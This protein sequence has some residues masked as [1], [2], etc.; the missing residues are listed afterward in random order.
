MK[1]NALWFIA[2]VTALALAGCEITISDGSGD[3]KDNAIHL[4]EGSFKN[5]DLAKDSEQWFS[6]T[7]SSAGTYYIHV[8]FGTIEYLNVRVFTLGGSPIGGE[9]ALWE[10][11][12]NWS[13][14]REFPKSGTYHIRVR[15]YYPGD[16]GAYRIAYNTS[17]VAP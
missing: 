4:F 12:T 14:S 2:L 7:V 11:G 3:G 15:P 9:A 8:I 13:F 5:G 17:A 10:R 6:F 1:R 16:S